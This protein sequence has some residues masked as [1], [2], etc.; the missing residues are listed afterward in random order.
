M[1]GAVRYL[2]GAL[3]LLMLLVGTSVAEAASGP[4]TGKLAYTE[5]VA[6]G[7]TL[8]VSFDEMNLTSGHLYRIDSVSQAFP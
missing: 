2:V 3:A 4:G 6:A 5:V 8:T 1:R 7:G